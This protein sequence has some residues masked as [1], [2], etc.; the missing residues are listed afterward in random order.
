MRTR[1]VKVASSVTWIASLSRSCQ[2]RPAS[3]ATPAPVPRRPPT[4]NT[5][6]PFDSTIVTN[7]VVRQLSLSAPGVVDPGPLVGPAGPAATGS[8]LGSAGAA[9]AAT[10]PTGCSSISRSISTGPRRVAMTFSMCRSLPRST[11]VRQT[12]PPA[13]A[14]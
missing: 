12:R 13:S 4:S 7:P 3:A 2:T 9:A 5:S 10:L 1:V 14:K 8:P 6:P 11:C